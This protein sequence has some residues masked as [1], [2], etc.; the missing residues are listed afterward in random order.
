M[1]YLSLARISS[2]GRV[3]YGLPEA[4]HGAVTETV[5]VVQNCDE[6]RQGRPDHG[7]IEPTPI[8][9]AVL[10]S[11]RATVNRESEPASPARES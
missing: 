6:P 4:D 9:D 2:P 10:S 5:G 1:Q 3:I 7:D 11:A 8:F